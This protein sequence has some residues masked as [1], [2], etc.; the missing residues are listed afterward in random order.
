MAYLPKAIIEIMHVVHSN[1]LV[2]CPY[3]FSRHF[4]Q[5]Y[6][7]SMLL[8][9]CHYSHWTFCFHF[10]IQSTSWGCKPRTHY[11]CARKD[12]FYCTPVH[13]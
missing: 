1:S 11:V 6:S 4:C 13:L 7:K 10:I 5:P 2:D 3:I 8:S 12:K 9:F